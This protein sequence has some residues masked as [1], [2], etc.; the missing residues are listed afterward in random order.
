MKQISSC[1]SLVIAGPFAED[2]FPWR[3][4]RQT[5]RMFCK[6]CGIDLEQGSQLSNP[7]QVYVFNYQNDRLMVLCSCQLRYLMQTNEGLLLQIME[8]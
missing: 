4:R 6:E 3:R 1:W 5:G 7:L 2:G 8:R